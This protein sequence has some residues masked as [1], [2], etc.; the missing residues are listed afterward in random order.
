[1]LILNIILLLLTFYLLAL[2]CDR[3]F[4]ESLEIISKKLK[5][6]S[7]ITGATFMAI[8]SS[9]PELFT[10]IFALF[11]IFWSANGNESIGA[12]TIV[13][14]AIF[15]I[16]VI[17]GASAIFL[18][19]KKNK[20][21]W[22]DRNKVSRQPII[23]DLIFYLLTICLLLLSFRDGKI[24]LRETAS[25]VIFY[26][27]YLFLV[28]NR[29]KRLKYEQI[30]ETIEELEEVEKKQ[31][32][33]KIFFKVLDIMIPNPKKW[34]NRFRWT[35]IISILL[36]AI[37]SHFMVN[38]AVSIANTLNIPKA[39]IW[40]TILAIWTSIPDLL[41]S[42]IVAKKW[43][44]DMAISNSLWSNIFDILIGL[45]LIYF[46]YILVSPNV[47][48]ITV[49]TNNLISSIILLLATAFVLLMFLIVQ[50]RKIKKYA[51]YFF[52]LLYIAFLTYKII[53]IF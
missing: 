2:I 18:N 17:I 25:L 43:K 53:Q 41:S 29:W 1:M 37:L 42:I 15:N 31:T 46:I 10:S 5:I 34:K 38:S 39:I 22:E 44:A 30:E 35:F 52:I 7:E 21:K 20:N 48:F 26:W 16:L 47:S 12:G 32:I 8:W 33:N 4:V 6:S 14:S 51:G 49:D 3:Y 11:T 28:K 40:L 50:R 13:W 45:W 9:A 24:V 27:I 23:R 19:W 36:I